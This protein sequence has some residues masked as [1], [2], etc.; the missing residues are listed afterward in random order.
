MQNHQWMW[1][2]RMLIVV[3]VLGTRLAT[4]G[5]VVVAGPAVKAVPATPPPAAGD[6]S[7]PAGVTLGAAFGDHQ[8]VAFGDVIVPAHRFRSGLLFI[9]PRASFND[10]DEREFNIGVG[11]RHLIPGRDAIL[12]GNLYYDS[13]D[14]ELDHQFSQVGFGL[15]FLS[16]WVDARWNYYLPQNDRE[17]SDT[18][19][20]SA[21]T[22]SR[23]HVDSEE[24]YFAGNEIRQEVTTINRRVKITTV[25]HW[26]TSEEAMEGYDAE[27]GVLLPIPRLRDMMDVKVFAGYYSFVGAFIEDATGFKARLEVRPLPSVYLD[28]ECFED[29]DFYGS[30]W[31]V[32]A[33]VQAPFDF[34]NLVR[35]RNPFAGALAGYTPGGPRVPIASRLTDM[36][37]R[38]ICIRTEASEPQEIVPDRKVTQETVSQTKDTDV[39]TIGRDGPPDGDDDGG[40]TPAE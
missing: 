19:E 15:E 17:H 20:S 22:E 29:E 9:N 2:G 30:S 38:D 31:L 18:Y 14:T 24:P 7:V 28:A 1:V 39:E 13:R 37:M 21:R 36:V 26:R 27:M 16:R 35:G 4:A 34:G 40:G 32:G 5:D 33:R 8:S 3:L 23:R 25:E 12:G 10:D 6:D 11:Y